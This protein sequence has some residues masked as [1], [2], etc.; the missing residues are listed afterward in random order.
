MG[1][2]SSLSTRLSQSRLPI[3]YKLA[4]V[5]ALLTASGMVLLGT[6]IAH[7]QSGRLDQQ[8]QEFGKTV[9]KQ[10]ADAATDPIM[11]GDKLAME[12]IIKKLIA[13]ERILGAAIYSEE[14]VPLAHVGII[15][16][17]HLLK[18]GNGEARM[19][20][21]DLGAMK[22]A[23]VPFASFIGSAEFEGV[24]TGYALV[25]FDHSFMTQARKETIQKVFGF[26]VILILVG[27]LISIA[28]GR[29]VS[30]PIHQLV[31]ASRSISRGDYHLSI[32][33]G[34]KDEVGHLMQSLSSMCEGLKQR[35]IL[36]ESLSRYVSPKVARAVMGNSGLDRLGGS[37]VHASVL[38]A[39]IVGFT[40]LSENMEP[41]EVSELLNEY[42]GYIA[43]AGN[44]CHG[45]VDKFIGDCAMLVFGA[46]EADRLHSF[47]ALVCAILIQKVI[48]PLNDA[49]RAKGLQ[50]VQFRIGVNSG[51]ML[52]GNMGTPERMNYTV[53][54][55]SVN[56]ASRLSALAG[57]DQVV[58]SETMYE[59]LKASGYPF[60]VQ[61]HGLMNI[62]GKKDPV[63]T[64]LVLDLDPAFRAHVDRI[65][66]RIMELKAA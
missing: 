9:A 16:P 57:P 33:P 2:L 7:D 39:D 43:R 66:G 20:E 31:D 13:N 4:L 15:P 46:P 14:M 12:I 6:I 5:F 45:H 42:F 23:P 54:G 37:H 35:E 18:K 47:H 48:R 29:R 8:S 59:T 60:K 21:W 51:M 34:R 19:L 63:A 27:G 50:T 44:V 28:L 25:T 55:D 40:S 22:G 53:I 30:Q 61:P 3:A 49:R 38:F 65:M 17:Q 1:L 64:Y 56:L 62:R 58:I 36:E 11:A 41:S 10:M 24:I 32:D 52:A 26:T